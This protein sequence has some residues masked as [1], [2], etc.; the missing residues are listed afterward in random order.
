MQVE[1]QMQTYI[2]RT[3]CWKSF[4]TSLHYCNL[5]LVVQ[6]MQRIDL[7]IGHWIFYHPHIDKMQNDAT[8]EMLACSGSCS[9][10]KI[11]CT[12][13]STSDW[14][15]LC[16]YGYC[17]RSPIHLATYNLMTCFIT[18]SQK[19]NKCY[20]ILIFVSN[21]SSYK[22]CYKATTSGEKAKLVK[23]MEHMPSIS[24]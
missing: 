24:S 5:L 3:K 21:V 20:E 12:A 4:Q 18:Q 15:Y 1:F 11:L 17:K 13:T 2:I 9:F 19:W 10:Q 16:L 14:T 23:F 7:W 22:V 6:L 8:I